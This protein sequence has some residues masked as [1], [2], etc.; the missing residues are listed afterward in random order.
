VLELRGIVKT[1]RIKARA[2]SILGGVDLRIDPGSIVWLRGA[3][4]AGK[5]T[6]LSIAGLLAPPDEGSVRIGDLNAETLRSSQ[7]ARIRASQIGFIF[8]H[9][10]LLADLTAVENVMLPSLTRAKSAAVR[11]RQLLCSLGLQERADF[12]ASLLS[13]GE[14]RRVAVARALVNSPAIVLAD[15]PVSDLDE[16]SSCRVLEHLAQAARDGRSVLIASHDERVSAIA[17]QAVHLQDGHLLEGQPV[18]STDDQRG[19]E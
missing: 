1:Y 16:H 17:H 14:R 19:S 15:E 7:R 11:C 5:T 8:Q 6:L 2:V 9:H 3:S 13:G 4:G 18:R 12:R 10:N